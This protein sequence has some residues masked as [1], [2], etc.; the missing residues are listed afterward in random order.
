LS[1]ILLAAEALGLVDERE[2]LLLLL[3]RLGELVALDRDLSLG[4]FPGALHREPLAH[5]HRARAG[6]G[7]REA[8]DEDRLVGR[9]RAGHAHHQA[10]HRDEAVVGAQHGGAQGVAPDGAVP[11]LEAR[12]QPPLH[13][14][15]AGVRDGGEQ[16]RVRALHRREVG[17]ERIRLA[18]VIAAS[19]LLLHRQ[20]RDHRLRTKPP[21]EP[22]DD[23]RAH[24]GPARRDTCARV[25]QLPLPERDVRLL[26][27]GEAAV[28]LAELLVRLDL[29]DGGVDR[30]AVD[31]LLPVGPEARDVGSGGHDGESSVWIDFSPR[32]WCAQGAGGGILAAR[33]SSGRSRERGGT[34][35]G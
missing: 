5:C 13:P 10:Q 28:D 23:A 22:H 8:G 30:G 34:R 6:Q 35:E 31:L 1:V 33:R 26:G 11:A 18:V 2:F 32:E 27:G 25:P 24:A 3:G 4:E 17:G 20:H 12:E 15:A 19:R 29:R 21:G 9:V 7:A 14:G 16:P